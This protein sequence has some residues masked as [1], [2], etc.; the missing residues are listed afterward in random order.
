M[1][2]V[3]FRFFD[4]HFQAESKVPQCEAAEAPFRLMFS[5]PVGGWSSLRAE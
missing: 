5:R 1:V 2:R 4:N 3:A